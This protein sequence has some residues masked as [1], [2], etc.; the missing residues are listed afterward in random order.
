MLD[1]I[2]SKYL[3]DPSK[4]ILRPL[5]WVYLAS[6]FSIDSI[7]DVSFSQPLGDLKEDK[8]K[9]NFLHNTKDNLKPM[10]FFTI[11]P[12]ILNLIPLWLMAKF[13][14]PHP[15]DNSPFGMVMGY[16]DSL[17]Y[18][19]RADPCFRFARRCARERYGEK[20]VEKND[21]LGV[22]VRQGMS[23]YEAERTGL[24]Q[25]YETPDITS[26]K[27]LTASPALQDLIP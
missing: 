17:G 21:M 13:L 3:S 7:T 25:L 16:V 1:L 20:K 8:D 2:E 11:F 12:E 19:T 24:F 26:Q 23:Q 22:F 14:A 6:Y 5:D 15:D 4:G 27:S 10:S 18:Q 9:L